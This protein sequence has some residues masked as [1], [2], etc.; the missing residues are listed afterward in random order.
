MFC[1]LFVFN[2]TFVLLLLIQ[3][4]KQPMFE[5]K[6]N[7]K[8]ATKYQRYSPITRRK[9]WPEY[10]TA[11][12]DV[13]CCFTHYTGDNCQITLGS[14]C[15]LS[16]CFFFPINTVPT[17]C[18]IRNG[19]ISGDGCRRQ[20]TKQRVCCVPCCNLVV[21]PFWG[22]CCLCSACSFEKLQLYAASCWT[23]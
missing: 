20:S 5:H 15:G 1:F 13:R 16:C 23:G 17:I 10:Y 14:S 18:S 12:Q 9:S 7:K 3:L 4:I 22:G 11:A 6:T 8:A 2:V 21:I 19:V